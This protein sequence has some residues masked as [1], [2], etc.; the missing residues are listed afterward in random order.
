MY[1]LIFLSKSLF[2]AL[3]IAAAFFTIAIDSINIGLT[4]KSPIS[5][6]LLDKCITEYR[7]GNSETKSRSLVSIK[8]V[9]HEYNA[10]WQYIRR[11]NVN[12]MRKFVDKDEKF[13]IVE[14]DNIKIKNYILSKLQ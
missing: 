6:Y 10:Q 14:N 8:R 11:D 3:T 13:D 2:F 4:R 12:S 1:L 9:P 5:K 7:K